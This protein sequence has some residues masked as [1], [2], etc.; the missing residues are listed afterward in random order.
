MLPSGAYQLMVLVTSFKYFKIKKTVAN[1]VGLDK[2]CGCGLLFDS[3]VSPILL[4]GSEVWG[5][6]CKF[7]DSDLT[8]KFHLKF[9]KKTLR[10]HCKAFNVRCRA[11]LNRRPIAIHNKIIYSIFNFLHHILTSE[12][13]LVLDIFT[14]LKNSNEWIKKMM[15]MLNSLGMSFIFNDF[16]NIKYNLN[17]IKQRI[18]DQ[19]MQLQNAEI[20]ES[21]KLRFFQEIYNMGQRPHYV[22]TLKNRND[23]TAVCKI[24]ISA[25]SLMIERGRYFNINKNERHCPICK[26][27]QVEDENHF[28]LKCKRFEQIRL[29]F[30][31]KVS[32]TLNLIF[33]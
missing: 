33:F 6:D 31:D 12:N 2:S 10:V 22:D 29:K 11:E 13:T 18:N 23:M 14:D 8:E 21:Q 4:Y 28:I 15:N 19:Y 7:K 17:S 32:K 1:N 5:V 26:T 9:I 3:L 16:S 24:R 20:H 25:H 27:G 30:Y